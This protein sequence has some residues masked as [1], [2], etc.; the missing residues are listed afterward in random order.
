MA[1]IAANNSN[2]N[3]F[4]NRRAMSEDCTSFSANRFSLGVNGFVERR[5]F[6]KVLMLRFS[7][8]K[9]RRSTLQKRLIA[10]K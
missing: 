2:S 6:T 9:M 4:A 5:G 10:A 3:R 8:A 1:G 7:F